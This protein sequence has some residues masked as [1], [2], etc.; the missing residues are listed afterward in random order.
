MAYNNFSDFAADMYDIH[1]DEE[2]DYFAVMWEED[3]ELTYYENDKTEHKI[4]MD[5]D[6]GNCK[7]KKLNMMWI[8]D[9]KKHYGWK[10][11]DVILL[12]QKQNSDNCFYVMRG[13]RD[14]DD[15]LR[16]EDE[17]SYDVA[18]DDDGFVV[19]RYYNSYK[20]TSSKLVPSFSYV[21]RLNCVYNDYLLKRN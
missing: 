19:K 20:W 10:T 9:I 15:E 5:N 1:Y 2:N 21:I 4:N 11:G 12:N 16:V 3:N 13:W 18:I 14:N 7:D 6:Y 17:K 8:D